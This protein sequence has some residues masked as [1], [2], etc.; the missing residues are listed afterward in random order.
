MF[1]DMRRKH[2]QVSDAECRQLLRQEKRA[3]FSV[4]GEDGYPYTVPINFYYEESDGTIYF[5]SAKTGHKADAMQTCDKV[6][7]TVWN[8]GYKTEG[9]WE[10]NV[11]S[12]VVFGRV[13]PIHDTDLATDR[14]RKL[15]TKYYPSQEE[16][17]REMSGPA[18]NRVQL[19][20][21][22]IDHMTGKLVNEK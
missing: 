15:A 2:Q 16:V 13:K 20:S 1:R 11:T 8:Q 3:A 10:W 14:L 12:V 19:F 17:D 7:L 22:E 5:H 9:H 21:I 4:M 6:C 18:M